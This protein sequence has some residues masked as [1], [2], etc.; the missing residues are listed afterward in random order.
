MSPLLSWVL[1][2]IGGRTPLTSYRGKMVSKKM[3]LYQTDH[4]Q[5][6]LK[7]MEVNR[8][9]QK[10]AEEEVQQNMLFQSSDS[11]L[12]FNTLIL[13]WL[14]LSLWVW[15]SLLHSSHGDAPMNDRHVQTE[16]SERGLS[17][18]PAGSVEPAA[19]CQRK[20]PLQPKLFNKAWTARPLFTLARL[21]DPHQRSG[22][23][24]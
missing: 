8:I 24:R 9:I 21:H 7:E 14:W 20:R 19:E 2:P 11:W 22:D 15:R 3:P 16:H 4:K 1:C 18:V 6:I 5:L 12:L 23:W 17:A 10:S 13:Y